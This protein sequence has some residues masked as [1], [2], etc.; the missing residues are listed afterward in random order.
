MFYVVLYIVVTKDITPF[1]IVG[2]VPAKI[3]RYRF[4]EEIIKKIEETEWWNMPDKKIKK[5]REE[6]E[7][8]Y[9]EQM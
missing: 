7:K 5:Q 4:S 8:E 6:I 3:I 9:D 1:A 2:G